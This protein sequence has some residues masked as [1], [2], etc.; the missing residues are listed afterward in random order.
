MFTQIFF[1]LLNINLP[2]YNILYTHVEILE[3]SR[4]IQLRRRQNSIEKKKNS[5]I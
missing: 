3:N 2:N 1:Y 4:K 5:S